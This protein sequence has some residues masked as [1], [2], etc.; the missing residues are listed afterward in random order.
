LIQQI[1]KIELTDGTILE[2]QSRDKRFES[3]QIKKAFREIVVA[4]RLDR[5]R[6]VL[7]LFF[8][9]KSYFQAFEEFGLPLLFVPV[10]ANYSQ[11]KDRVADAITLAKER[12]KEEFSEFFGRIMP[13]IIEEYVAPF[14]HWLEKTTNQTPE[15]TEE[16]FRKQMMFQA[17]GKMEES[18]TEN[19]IRKFIKKHVSP[20][21]FS[22]ALRLGRIG[23]NFI[24]NRLVE[25]GI[26][27]YE[28]LAREISD[29]NFKLLEKTT[30]ALI[31]CN[32]VTPLATIIVCT[33]P[34]C[35][36][37][38]IMISNIISKAHC[39]KCKSDALSVTSAFINEPYL[40][41]KDKMLDL[42]AIL[43]SYIGSKST[44]EYI[45]GQIVPSLRCF[46][47]SYV[48]KTSNKEGREVDA[49]IYSTKT[50]KVIPVEIKMHQIRSQLPPNRLQNIL[51][52]DLK[53]LAETLKQ[54]GLGKGCYT[55]NLKIPD[56]ETQNIKENLIPKI[57]EGEI[58]IISATDETQFLNR[59]DLL[60]EDVQKET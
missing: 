25:K 37:T 45:D 5:T 32:V 10:V 53:Q 54:I 43:C 13:I 26:E 2:I 52:N 50:K 33:N 12:A 41:I 47:T 51:N 46:L 49:L 24:S 30:N 3:P 36:H 4:T 31:E 35:K 23:F 58:E 27:Q 20:D 28:L 59:V 55:T 18:T 11:Y 44:Y 7:R 57:F 29:N 15:L 9:H 17:I 21:I 40:Q 19:E 34:H 22:H 6:P 8:V 16:E 42:H 39:A 14:F 48:R 56:E 1:D 38:E 60:I